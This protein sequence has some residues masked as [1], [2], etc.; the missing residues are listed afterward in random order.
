M[1]FARYIP[2][3]NIFSLYDDVFAS[4]DLPKKIKDIGYGSFEIKLNI[5]KQP[6]I[7]TFESSIKSVWKER[8]GYIVKH[9]LTG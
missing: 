4:L 5:Y 2:I 1:P 3:E 8:I 9:Y 6:N 7:T